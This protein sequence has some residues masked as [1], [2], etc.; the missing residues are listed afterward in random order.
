MSEHSR[1]P[2]RFDRDVVLAAAGPEIEALKAEARAAVKALQILMGAGVVLPILFFVGIFVGSLGALVFPAMVLFAVTLI[3]LGLHY[4]SRLYRQRSRVMAAVAPAL[5]LTFTPRADPPIDLAPFEG[6]YYGGLFKYARCD[7]VLSGERAGVAFQVFDAKV[8]ARSK[9]PDGTWR[10]GHPPKWLEGVAFHVTRVVRVTVPGRWTAR[11]VILP[12]HGLANRLQRPKGMDR[13]RLVDAGFEELFEVFST[14]QTEARAL[15]TPTV[16]ERLVA[17]EALFPR[18]ADSEDSPPPKL[19][20]F[21]DGVLMTAMPLA[22][23]RAWTK[24]KGGKLTAGNVDALVVDQVLWEIDAVLGVVDAVA[25][26]AQARRGAEEA[27]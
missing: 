18:P 9:G 6:T 17:L 1:R 4:A 11:T 5:G 16:M 22:H 7:D 23:G 13:V 20:V 26:P 25:G 15:L 21:E 8:T 10:A 27:T 14:D 19:A 24:A 12:D 2:T 3:G